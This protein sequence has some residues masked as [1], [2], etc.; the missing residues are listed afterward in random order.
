MIGI[1]IAV[2]MI[3]LK[4]ILL[5]NSLGNSKFNTVSLVVR[6][7]IKYSVGSRISDVP[8]NGILG[9]QVLRGE[10][11]LEVPKQYNPIPSKILDK[12]NELKIIIRDSEGNVY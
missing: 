3:S 11:I 6:E 8:S 7:S 5:D 1:K 2:S 12:A 10:Y 4:L 9:G